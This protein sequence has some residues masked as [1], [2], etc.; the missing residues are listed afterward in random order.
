MILNQ[1]AK[2]NL[3]RLWKS[4]N[5][6]HHTLAFKILKG[7]N[8]TTVDESWIWSVYLNLNRTHKSY[9]TL[10]HHEHISDAEIVNGKILAQL[11]SSKNLVTIHTILSYFTEK[12]TI[13]LPYNTLTFIP[14]FIL[15]F[16]KDIQF[17]IWQDG[18]LEYL[19]EKIILLKNVKLLDFRRQPI[20][21]IHPSIATLQHLKEVYLISTSFIPIELSERNDVDFYTDAPY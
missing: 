12:N 11:L 18:E 14:H 7:L 13:R 8:L 19:D 1:E 9:S 16:S 17:F 6:N 10:K 3:L 20:T 5:L 2:E 4:K 21:Q 15:E